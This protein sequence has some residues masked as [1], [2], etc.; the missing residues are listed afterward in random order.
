MFEEVHRPAFNDIKFHKRHFECFPGVMWTHQTT[1][2]VKYRKLFDIR[3]R[4][5]QNEC[6]SLISNCIILIKLEWRTTTMDKS[7]ACLSPTYI[8][9]IWHGFECRIDLL[10]IEKYLKTYYVL[11]FCYFHNNSKYF[12]IYVECFGMRINFLNVRNCWNRWKLVLFHFI[13][14]FFFFLFLEFK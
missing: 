5:K 13:Y 10:T 4:T 6:K 12:I 1:L 11:K 14:I 8:I 7:F 9:I 2:C 3:S